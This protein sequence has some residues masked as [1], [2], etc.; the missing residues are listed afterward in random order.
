MAVRK[1]SPVFRMKGGLEQEEEVK[2]AEEQGTSWGGGRV[3]PLSFLCKGGHSRLERSEGERHLLFGSHRHPYFAKYFFFL[4]IKTVPAYF[5]DAEDFREVEDES[6][7]FLIPKRGA[8]HTMTQKGHRKSCPAAD[9]P[10]PH[11]ASPGHSHCEAPALLLTQSKG[12]SHKLGTRQAEDKGSE[13][14]DARPQEAGTKGSGEPSPAP[15]GEPP[16]VA[17]QPGKAAP[18]HTQAEHLA[19]AQL[20]GPSVALRLLIPREPTET[21]SELGTDRRCRRL[22]PEASAGGAAVPRRAHVCPDGRPD[23]R[24]PPGDTSRSLKPCGI[25]CTRRTPTAFFPVSQASFNF[26]SSSSLEQF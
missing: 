11:G 21:G 17:G 8:A 22:W 20:H 13:L 6:S 15:R 7:S 19:Q 24:V 23:H 3:L 4:V 14:R 2:L 25:F 12:C 16:R 18:A 9:L 10:C 1:K 26:S 5:E